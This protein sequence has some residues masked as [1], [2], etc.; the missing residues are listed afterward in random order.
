MLA[1]ATEISRPI[2]FCLDPNMLEDNQV[3]YMV[4]DLSDAVLKNKTS[5]F[6][7]RQLQKLD[8][9]NMREIFSDARAVKV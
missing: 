5:E 2:T 7:W 4:I 6:R 9:R 1:Y 3:E 8:M